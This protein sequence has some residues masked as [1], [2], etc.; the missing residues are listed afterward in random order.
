MEA[1]ELLRDT[2]QPAL[3]VLDW[4]MPRMCGKE[5][6]VELRSDPKLAAIPVVLM[7]AEKDIE[8]I[9]AKVSVDGFVRKISDAADILNVV[10][11]ALKTRM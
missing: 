8:E 1:L 2:D 10:C 9:A 5:F 7:S 11:K 6:L 4:N 3:I